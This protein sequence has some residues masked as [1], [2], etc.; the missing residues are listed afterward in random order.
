MGGGETRQVVQGLV[1]CGEDL[2][3]YP[4]GSERLGGCD[5]GGWALTQVLTGAL[6]W[7]QREQT[8]QQ[9]PENPEMRWGGS[10]TAGGRGR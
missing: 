4:Q 6:W 1:G 7:L 10:G 9:G 8:R 2:V 5:R 3:F